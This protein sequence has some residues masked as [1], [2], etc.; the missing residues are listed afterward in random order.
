MT[1]I[2][3][4]HNIL[5]SRYENMDF[6]VEFQEQKITLS[7]VPSFGAQFWG[8]AK[9][10]ICGVNYPYANIGMVIMWEFWGPTK[11]NICG[12]SYLYANICMVIMWQFWGAAKD[13][14][15]WGELSVC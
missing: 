12:V 2:C 14:H 3:I 15:M 1:S 11:D 4:M 6:W 8:A 9:D 10:N 5:L 13:K 7:T